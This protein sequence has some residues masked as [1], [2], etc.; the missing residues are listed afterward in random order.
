MRLGRTRQNRLT[1]DRNTDGFAVLVSNGDIDVGRKVA[2]VEFGRKVLEHIQSVRVNV[3]FVTSQTDKHNID[4]VQPYNSLSD[5]H[6]VVRELSDEL[7][8]LL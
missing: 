4:H 8:R 7:V 5:G 1:T 2:S 3:E 6:D